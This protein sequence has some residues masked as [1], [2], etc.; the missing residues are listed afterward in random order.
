MTV[1]PQLILVS[2]VQKKAMGKIIYLEN[3]M[4]RQFKNGTR[5]SAVT[6]EATRLK[7]KAYLGAIVDIF[8]RKVQCCMAHTIET[9]DEVWSNL[10]D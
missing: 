9:W 1:I 8:K 4:M 3:P 2:T 6:H 10:A 5:D 7:S